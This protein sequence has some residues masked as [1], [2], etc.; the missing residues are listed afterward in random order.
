M[1]KKSDA[2]LLGDV[3]EQVVH[4]RDSLGSHRHMTLHREVNVEV[5]YRSTCYVLDVPLQICAIKRPKLFLIDGYFLRF[6]KKQL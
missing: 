1:F 4:E 2:D 3:V 5:G 6:I